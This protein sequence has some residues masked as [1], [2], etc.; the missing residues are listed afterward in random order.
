V[1]EAVRGS[2]T[3]LISGLIRRHG[4]SVATIYEADPT[5]EITFSSFYLDMDIIRR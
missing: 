1:A 2:T 4:A 5:A 3:I